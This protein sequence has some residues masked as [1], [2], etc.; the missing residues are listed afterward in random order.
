MWNACWHGARATSPFSPLP[1]PEDGRLG[2]RPLLVLGTL[3]SDESSHCCV[4]AGEVAPPLP[5]GSRHSPLLS[6]EPA[7]CSLPAC[8]YAS[9]PPIHWYRSQGRGLPGPPSQEVA[10]PWVKARRSRTQTPAQGHRAPQPQARRLWAGQNRPVVWPPR[11]A[12]LAA[13]RQAS[14]FLAARRGFPPA[15]APAPPAPS[16]SRRPG[17][18]LKR[19]PAPQTK[20]SCL[21]KLNQTPGSRHEEVGP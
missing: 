3:H 8:I 13:T 14:P 18:L 2:G 20:H 17:I 1:K 12:S 9:C 7:P 5:R 19:R 4:T 15:W 16:P 21:P 6:S 11:P 10:E